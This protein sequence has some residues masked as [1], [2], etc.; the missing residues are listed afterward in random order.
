VTE[1]ILFRKLGLRDGHYILVDKHPILCDD[2]LEWARWFEHP[3][4][5]RV[6]LTRV[7]PYFVSTVFLGLDHSFERFRAREG[8]VPILFETMAWINREHETKI[9]SHTFKHTRDWEDIQERC[10]TWDEAIRQ[11]EDVIAGMLADNPGDQV[12]ELQDKD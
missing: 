5:R 9:G 8:H 10:A 6:R 3:G 1:P 2:L 12:E 4:N 11:H 7:G